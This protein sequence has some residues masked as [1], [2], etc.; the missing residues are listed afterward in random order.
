MQLKE[1][2]NNTSFKIYLAVLI[3]ILSLSLEV[4][5]E[6][7]KSITVAGITNKI[8]VEYKLSKSSPTGIY[9]ELWKIWSRKTG[10]FVNY[11]IATPEEAETGLK[12]GAVDVIMGYVPRDKSNHLSMSGVIYLS[13]IY[14]YRNK[15]ILSAEKISELPPYR[16]G[17]T[18]H[19]AAKLEEGSYQISYSIK[20]TVPELLTATEE[21]EINVFIAEDALAN[22]EL[23]QS[24]LWRKFIQSSEPLFSYGVKAAVRSENID[25]LQLVNSGF[26]R[27]T[28]TEKLLAERTWAGGNFKYR[29]HGDL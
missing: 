25:L 19:T 4:K 18:A 1:M 6:N 8:P 11:I 12:N 16:V 7:L 13:S 3:A 26:S 10:I 20:K 22:H 9:V 14:I 28:D 23:R 29:Y 15:S 21:G 2:C 5:A 24:G 17:V 27:I